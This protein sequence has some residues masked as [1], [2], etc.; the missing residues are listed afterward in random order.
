MF[1]IIL[2]NI[3]LVKGRY[4]A[5]NDCS[6]LLLWPYAPPGEQISGHVAEDAVIKKVFRTGGEHVVQSPQ[7]GGYEY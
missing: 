5:G 3:R 6:Y 4:L 2:Q 1:V 7:L